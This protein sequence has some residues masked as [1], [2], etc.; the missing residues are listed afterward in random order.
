[1]SLTPSAAWLSMKS[2]MMY[3]FGLTKRERLLRLIWNIAWG[4]LCRP[5]PGV[6]HQWRILILRCFG[7]DVSWSAHVYPSVKVWAPWRLKMERRSCLGPATDCYNVGYITLREGS[8]VSQGAYLCGASHE[9]R[10]STFDLVAGNIEIGRCAWVCARAIVGPGVVVGAG[11]VIALGCV[12]SRS[13]PDGVV[14]GGNPA[15][16]LSESGRPLDDDS[17]DGSVGT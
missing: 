2:E 6:L 15:R 17:V 13:V 9:F 10:R 8:I 3:R 5:T 4:L 16:V 7:A 14:V 1:M 12:A 11:A